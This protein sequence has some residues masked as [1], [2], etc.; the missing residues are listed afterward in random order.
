MA[1]TEADRS[2]AKSVPDDCAVIE[3][4]QYTL[5]PGVRDTFLELFDREFIESQEVLGSWVIGQFRDL[6]DPDR[7][8]WLRGFRDMPARAEAL[9]AFYGGP[10]WRAHREA[11]NATIIDSD[12]VLLLRPAN[13]L[14]FELDARAP[15]GEQETARGMIVATICYFD[16]PVDDE[17]LAFFEQDIKPALLETGAHVRAGFVT[18]SS[19]NN[20]RLPVR[21]DEQVF[22][23]LAGFSDSEAYQQHVA[24]LAD[25]ANW[26]DRV[27]G[28]LRRRI[29]APPEILRLGPTARSRLQGGPA[30]A[31]RARAFVTSM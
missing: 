30:S 28:E 2:A 8:V 27:A 26:R 3:L 10:I 5:H 12:N 1:I 15:P 9:A 18:E 17:F 19:A 14:P 4:R 11:A 31:L 13:G 25:S 24:A 21:E 20:F 7:V 6:D 16:A 22:V 23:W 29:M